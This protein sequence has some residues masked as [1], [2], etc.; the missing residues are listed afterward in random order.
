MSCTLEHSPASDVWKPFYGGSGW[1]TLQL[2]PVL[3]FLGALTPV[4]VWMVGKCVSCW[5]PKTGQGIG[6][7]LF[8]LNHSKEKCVVS[9]LWVQS[10]EE[11]ARTE[12]LHSK[13]T[14]SKLTATPL[15]FHVLTLI[16]EWRKKDLQTNGERSQGSNTSS[17]HYLDP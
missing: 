1:A 10:H 8:E 5:R 9:D 17:C 14:Q 15:G 2:F 12:A 7:F 3:P 16:Y 13:V 4:F 11:I 6:K